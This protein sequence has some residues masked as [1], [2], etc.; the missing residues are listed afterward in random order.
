[1]RKYFSGLAMALGAF[2]FTACEETTFDVS[3]PFEHTITTA[4]EIPANTGDVTQTDTTTFDAT[5]DEDLEEQLNQVKDLKIK[6]V[7]VNITNLNNTDSLDHLTARADVKMAFGPLL[8]IEVF[9]TDLFGGYATFAEL[10][11][12]LPLT[13]TAE[14]LG[15]SS[16]DELLATLKAGDDAT[17]ISNYSATNGTNN[18]YSFDAVI[19]VKFDAT[20]ELA[21]EEE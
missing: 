8:D 14:D 2:A 13:Y 12:V 15:V 20:A 21:S 11:E 4:V 9:N 17:F 1:M 3:L 6:E 5:V 10:Y 18:T 16:I 7:V 19:T